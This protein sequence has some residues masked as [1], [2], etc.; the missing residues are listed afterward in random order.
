[1]Q[2]YY[3]PPSGRPPAWPDGRLYA[4]ED[5]LVCDEFSRRLLDA[6]STHSVAIL[7][8]MHRTFGR[9]SKIDSGRLTCAY[10]F[11]PADW[12]GKM[13]F[14][15]AAF[16]CIAVLYGVDA[17]FFDGRYGDGMDRVISSIYLH[18]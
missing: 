6:I 14:F 9:D 8:R 1:V 11:F 2:L 15:G 18:W 3:A 4:C 5:L 12:E 13:R 17:F 7:K 10:R 16:V